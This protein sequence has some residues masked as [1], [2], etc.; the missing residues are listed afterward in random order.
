M[1]N[2]AKRFAQVVRGHW[3]VENSLHWSLNVSFRE[4]GCRIRQGQGAE[5]F[6]V[7]RHIALSLLQQE[8]TEKV[9]IESKRF[10]AELDT[11]YLLKVLTARTI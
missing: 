7:V 9:G 1:Q 8:K 10:R 3:S 6:A 2:D 11:R 5:N 4:D